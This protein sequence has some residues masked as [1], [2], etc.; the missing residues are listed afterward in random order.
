ME[1]GTHSM[2]VLARL[3]RPQSEGEL[4][5]VLEPVLLLGLALYLAWR[6]FDPA[7]AIRTPHLAAVLVIALFAGMA[8]KSV[9]LVHPPSPEFALVRG[10]VVYLCSLPFTMQATGIEHKTLWLVSTVAVYP[11][12]MERWQT[13]L[14]ILLV[15]AVDP[16][17]SHWQRL[18]LPADFAEHVASIA[19]LG[20]LSNLLGLSLRRAQRSLR[21]VRRGESRLQSIASNTLSVIQILDRRYRLKYVNPTVDRLLGYRADEFH[22]MWG[23][24]LVHHD[25]RRAVVKELRRLRTTPK[26][27]SLLIVRMRHKNG[28]WRWCEARSVNLLHDPSVKG[29]VVTMNDITDRVQTEKRLFEERNLLRTVIEAVPEYIYTKDREGRYLLSNAAHLKLLRVRNEVELIGRR[30]AEIFPRK[31]AEQLERE[32]RI[33]LAT[34]EPIHGT[35]RMRDKRGPEH[36]RWLDVSKIPL[37]DAEKHV[38]GMVG[39]TRDVT[40]RKRFQTLL[41]YQARHDALTGLPNRRHI[42]ELI[43]SA[44]EEERRHGAVTNLTMAGPGSS[45]FALI[46]CDLD[47]FKS[48]ND[49]HGHDVGD[50]FLRIIAQRIRARMGPTETL[51][52]LGGDEFVVLCRELTGEAQAYRVAAQVLDAV[53]QPLKYDD[54]P[55]KVEASIG[56]AF[57]RPDYTQPSQLMRDA[58]TAMYQAKERGRNR[59]AVFD[60][61]LRKRALHRAR[62]VQSLRT[63]LERNEL[64][65]LYQPKVSLKDGELIGVEVLMRWQSQEHGEVSPGLFIP[66]AEESALIHSIGLWS[67]REALAQMR[68]WQE[69]Y[70]QARK[71]SMAINVSMRQMLTESFPAHLESLIRQA[72]IAPQQLELELTESAAMV[73]PHRSVEMLERL[74][75]LGVRIALD[76]FGTGYSTLASMRRLPLD[77][78]KIDRAFVA[79]LGQNVGDTEIVRMV[80]ALTETLGIQCVA[81]GIETQPV[82]QELTRLGCDIG[83]GFVFSRPVTGSEIGDLLAI[84]H[85]FTTAANS[86]GWAEGVA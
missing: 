35:Q 40:H 38:V 11:I 60:D 33:V 64:K 23:I 21:A 66:L 25:D 53:R 50:K 28:N 80:L 24:S 73:N 48:V 86:P 56:V 76:D 32:D 69:K 85:P 77:V 30:P 81:E 63:A 27:R 36:E 58:D 5:R 43:A 6:L 61:T 54:T 16:L 4:L 82:L 74:K 9:V 70:P 18:P 46:F 59:I 72:G 79:G 3:R 39:V 68:A 75:H 13:L 55:L 12:V 31:L 34:G 15:A 78:V 44:M 67:V 7:L 10:F 62:L 83:Q 51:G 42:I 26:Q 41:E 47:F 22:S 65:L 19:V 37:R 84:G 14:F 17:V 52:R 49:T 8:V 71:L 20:L 29:I 57:N 1:A 2:K 45:H